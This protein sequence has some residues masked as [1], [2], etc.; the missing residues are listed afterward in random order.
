MKRLYKAMLIAGM[1]LAFSAQNSAAQ[2]DDLH[3]FGYFQA[4]FLHSIPEDSTVGKKSNTFN[5]QQLNVFLNKNLSDDFSAFIN[6]EFTNSFSSERNW[7]S[8]NLEEAWMKYS[9]N[10]AFNVKAGMLI[11]EFNNLNEIKNKTP[12]LP[13]IIRPLVYEASIATLVNLE[14]YVP[15]R[16]FVQVYG[17]LPIA[18][19]AKFHYAVYAGNSDKLHINGG[20]GQRGIDTTTYKMIGG[21]VGLTYDNLK[22]GVSGT[23][24]REKPAAVFGIVEVPRTR[25]GADLSY[26]I[27]GFTL[28]GEMIMVRY[29]LSDAEQHKLDSV[30]AHPILKYSYAPSLDKTFYYANLAYNITSDLYL[31]AGY[32]YMDDKSSRF[33][34]TGFKGINV[35]AGYRPI[36]EIVLKAQY[37]R[38]DGGYERAKYTQNSFYFAA[39]VFF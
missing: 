1:S 26:S 16:A 6:L 21:R 7:G 23:Y 4:S 37:G 2:D 30:G 29:T 12:L 32:G 19:A 34:E 18:D 11:P 10:D 9:A 39:S 15:N 31:Y 17:K 33:W 38:Y 28:E 20:T 3:I 25:V 22:I 35:G 5:V 8:L 13:Y 27:A 14:N 24:D 36:D